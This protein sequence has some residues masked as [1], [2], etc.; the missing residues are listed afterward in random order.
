[1][2]EALLRTAMEESIEVVTAEVLVIDAAFEHVVDRVENAV[3][4]REGSALFAG[5][6]DDLPEARL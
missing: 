1:L 6:T 5:S 4:D 2:H 3:C